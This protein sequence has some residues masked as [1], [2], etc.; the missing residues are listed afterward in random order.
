MCDAISD[1]DYNCEL[2]FFVFSQP[3]LESLLQVRKMGGDI[4]I[5]EKNGPGTL[6]RLCLV[7]GTSS[8]KTALHCDVELANHS[9]MVSIPRALNIVFKYS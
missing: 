3:C 7:L 1:Q 8:D 5:I 2:Y 6:M 9:L 4:K